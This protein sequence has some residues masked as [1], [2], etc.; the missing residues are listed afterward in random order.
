MPKPG[1]SA[2]LQVFR[3]KETMIE[4]ATT[5]VQEIQTGAHRELLAQF[6]DGL[7]DGSVVPYFQRIVE[8]PSMRTVKVEVLARWNHPTLGLVGPT[9]FVPL[10]EEGGFVHELDFAMVVQALDTVRGLRARRWPDLGV[11]LN[12]SP[13]TLARP[14]TPATIIELIAQSGV[15]LSAVCI[16]ATESALVGSAARQSIAELSAAGARI[17]LD[18]F[19]TGYATLTNLHQLPVDAIKIDRS[20]VQSAATDSAASA[21]IQS[22]VGIGNALGICVIAE[23]V[24]T[25]LEERVVRRL[26]VSILQ[27]YRY[28]RPEPASELMI[29]HHHGIGESG[30]KK[31]PIRPQPAGFPINEEQRLAA[32]RQLKILDTPPE[33]AFDALTR[34]AAQICDVPIAVVSLVDEDRQWFKS[35][36]GLDAKE[37]PREV[38][39]CAHA[40]L[41]NETMVVENALADDRFAN[42]PLVVEDPSIRFY[43]GAPLQTSDGY[44]LGTLCVIDR[45]T[46]HLEPDQL[47]LLRAIADHVVAYLELRSL[48]NVLL[49]TLEAKNHAEE[50]LKWEIEHDHLTGL[51]NRRRFMAELKSALDGAGATVVNLDIDNFSRVNAVLGQDVGDE[52]LFQLA[53]SIRGCVRTTAVVARISGDGFAILFPGDS[54]HEP[55]DG[56]CTEIAAAVET[57]RLVKGYQLEVSASIG[58]AKSVPGDTTYSLLARADKVMN[59]QKR[60]KLLSCSQG[61]VDY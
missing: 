22:I 55:V 12:L 23:G 29:P 54:T 58:C 41:G 20:F 28:S 31:R 40:I 17:A 1:A 60:S 42:N 48:N 19:G 2:T 4:I 32:L 47:L 59:A 14:G 21:V 10:A 49:E 50:L 5:S 18:D 51:A 9:V 7:H 33:E 44:N 6:R 53:E 39:F 38:A 27:G 8:L 13:L 30:I 35:I 24:E 45:R 11:A 52:L 43:A 25:A 15:P 16:E 3:K 46:R 57:R 26:G 34:L 61:L 56:F 37:T 36:V